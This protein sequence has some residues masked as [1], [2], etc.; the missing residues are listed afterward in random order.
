MAW[1]ASAQ[2]C[3]SQWQNADGGNDHWYQAVNTPFGITWSAAALES[4][5]RGGTLV[6]ITSTEENDHVFTVIDGTQF[7]VFHSPSSAYLGPW[8]G[9]YQVPGAPEPDQGWLWV[10]GEGM[11]YTRWHPGQ[12]ND[13]GDGQQYAHFWVGSGPIRPTWQD[14]EWNPS[15][16]IPGYVI[17]FIS[18]PCRADV[19]TQGA[20]YADPEF[21]MKDCVVS[22]ADLNYYVNDWVVGASSGDMT[23][24]GAPEGDPLYGVPD[25]QVTAA[26]LNYFVNAWVRGCP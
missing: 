15:V 12:P 5:A 24:Q 3:I 20:S 10:T 19:T 18:D 9:A 17:E 8:I 23:T 21:G 7:W 1:T 6:S 2:P 11:S 16:T 26:D 22:V 13:G 25:G 14:L 4:V